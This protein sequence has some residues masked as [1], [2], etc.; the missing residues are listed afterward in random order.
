MP[1]LLRNKLNILT[2]IIIHL[3][4]KTM[5]SDRTNGQRTLFDFKPFDLYSVRLY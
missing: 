4:E 2:V 5:I 3:N 1:G